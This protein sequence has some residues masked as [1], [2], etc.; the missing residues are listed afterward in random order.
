MADKAQYVL[1][2]IDE[3]TDGPYI[4]CEDIVVELDHIEFDDK[5]VVRVYRQV[6]YEGD[7]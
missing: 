2:E 3:Y 1:R 4:G 6:D 5:G 7:V